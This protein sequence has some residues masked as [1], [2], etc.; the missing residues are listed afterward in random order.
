MPHSDEQQAR[1]IAQN[2]RDYWASLGHKVR[3]KVIKVLTHQGH[4]SWEVHSN[5]VNGLPPNSDIP[6]KLRERV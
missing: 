3:V 2:I 6:R 5:L 4:S 1:E